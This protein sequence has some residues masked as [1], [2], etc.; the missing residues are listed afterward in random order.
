MY[1]YDRRKT[2]GA[3][4]NNFQALPRRATSGSSLSPI[5]AKARHL[6]DDFYAMVV[7]IR[8]SL[9]GD[10][11]TV[12]DELRF[13]GIEMREFCTNFFRKPS[14]MTSAMIL[15]LS[16]QTVV[17]GNEGL[18][19]HMNVDFRFPN[20]SPDDVRFAVEAASRFFTNIADISFES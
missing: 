17:V 12:S 13:A 19:I 16:D 1:S 15:S 4:F 14:S 10:I 18:R 2:A 7:E 8:G 3:F 11:Q 5:Q 9:K 20:K 6:R